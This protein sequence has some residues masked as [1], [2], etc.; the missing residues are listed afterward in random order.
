MPS[1]GATISTVSEPD[2]LESWKEIAAYLRRD[3][4]TVQRWER[5]EGMPVHR[6]VHDKLGSVYAFRAELDDWIRR[7]GATRAETAPESD[8]AVAEGSRAPRSRRPL[9]LAVAGLAAVAI[10]IG[11]TAR[12]L[13]GRDTASPDVL[14]QA[15]F[16]R[17]TEFPGNEQAAALSRDGKFAAFLSDRDGSMDVWI[18]QIG[19]GRFY[20]LTKDDDKELDN[21]SIRTM[22]F[23][24]DS[25]H[26]TFWTRMFDG[27]GQ[28]AIGIWTAPVLG[29][30]ARPHLE[31]VAEVDWSSDGSRLVY[32]TPADGDP[33]FVREPGEPKGKQ[34]FAASP[35]QHAHFPV[36]SPDDRFIYFVQGSL[37]P[38]R[39]DIW[40]IGVG[41]GTPE[42][43]TH[44]EARVT[45]PVF[46][47]ARTLMYLARDAEGAGPWL[48]AIDVERRVPHR[49]GFGLERYTSLAGS[50]DGTRLVATLAVQQNAL[51]R[52]PLAGDPVDAAAARRLSLST[53][54]GSSP[55]LGAGFLLY[56]SS[57]SGSDSIWKLTGELATEIWS[58]PGE[59]IVGAPAISP[60]GG[61]VA[62]ATRRNNAASLHV[63]ASDG[64]NARV[65]TRALQLQGTPAWTRDGRAITVAALVDG[66]SRLF[67]VPLD[68]GAPSQFVKDHA[69]DPVWSPDGKFLL[70]SG[71][72]VGT[73]FTVKAVAADGRPYPLP[74]LTLSRGERHLAFL[75]GGRELVV[76]RGEIGHKNLWRIDLTSGAERQLTG[77]TRE[78]RVRD[79]DVS[80]DGR[81]VVLEQSH[82]AS[83]IVLIERPRR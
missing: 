42:R 47:D 37:V 71:P 27:K 64:A 72:D 63:I 61:S 66:T 62:F 20:N 13:G 29:G 38:D 50:T 56:V 75:P 9:L 1:R 5:R 74:A 12:Y 43:I 33:M 16:V 18:T 45:H 17:L 48:Y 83:D 10:A 49:I 60:D 3:V 55:R 76:L 35:G 81:D 25:T 22:G 59:R 58:V 34:I 28:S 19:S 15:R 82:E 77:F 2:R 57:K 79:F 44:H 8:S 31:Q 70:Y 14:A 30:P 6:H 51:W 65:V 26:V 32:H 68:G 41:G 23:S 39:L 24:P 80:P 7:R 40:R 78:F 73:T 46:L 4:T 67:N 36:W 69:F 21:A 54:S 52:V 53:G 11:F